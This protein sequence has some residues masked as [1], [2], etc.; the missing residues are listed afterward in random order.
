MS[1]VGEPLW[2]FVVGISVC[3]V[4]DDDGGDA[5]SVVGAGH[6]A[7]A[8]LPCGVPYHAACLGAVDGDYF[9]TE[10]DSDCLSLFLVE[11]VIDEAVEAGGFT[12]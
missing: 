2:N 6:G 1:H 7:V 12:C 8:F 5:A 4:V 3:D 10:F 11:D 9:G